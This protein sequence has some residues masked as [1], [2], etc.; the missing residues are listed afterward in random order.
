MSVVP[1]FNE[2]Q[3]QILLVAETFICRKGFDG[4][5]IRNIERSPKLISP[6][7]LI[8][9]SKERLLESLIFYRT[10]TKRFR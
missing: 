9:G 5:S 4:T 6:W 2:K 7:F 10:R 1:D 3:I 8:F